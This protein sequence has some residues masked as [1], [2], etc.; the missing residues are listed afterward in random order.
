MREALRLVNES[1]RPI[2]WFVL[3][4]A[5][6]SDID[7]SS[8]EMMKNLHEILSRNNITFVITIPIPRLKDQLERSGLIDI[9]GEDKVFVNFRDAVEAFVEYCKDDDSIVEW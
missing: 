8:A 9:I 2:K 1:R 3:D 5:G 4:T 6:F 7:Y